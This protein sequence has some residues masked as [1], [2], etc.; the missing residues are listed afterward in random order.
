[1]S[2]VCGTATPGAPGGAGSRAEGACTLGRWGTAGGL[3]TCGTVGRPRPP[4]DAGV[5]AA[6]EQATASVHVIAARGRQTRLRGD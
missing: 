1:M 3:G 6:T 4:A 5:D 2:D